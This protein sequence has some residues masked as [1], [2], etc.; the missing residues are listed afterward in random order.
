MLTLFLLS[1]CTY[2]P[3]FPGFFAPRFILA[4]S[5]GVA[6]TI[7]IP[8]VRGYGRV[9]SLHLSHHPAASRSGGVSRKWARGTEGAQVPP[10]PHGAQC[11]PSFH[12]ASL[13]IIKIRKNFRCLYPLTFGVYPLLLWKT[14]PF[15]TFLTCC[16]CNELLIYHLCI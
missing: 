3:H 6:L 12:H 4:N 2:R 8:S 10:S 1:F 11:P 5:R 9:H 7:D 13:A 15:I 16:F 14:I